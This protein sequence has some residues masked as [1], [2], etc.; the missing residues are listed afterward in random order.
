MRAE[1]FSSSVCFVGNKE[2]SWLEYGDIPF[3]L[4]SDTGFRNGRKEHARRRGFKKATEAVQV[5]F[6]VVQIRSQWQNFPIPSPTLTSV[7]FAALAISCSFF[8][9]QMEW[10]N[11]QDSVLGWF[12]LK[13]KER[14]Y[15]L[16]YC[17]SRIKNVIFH[18]PSHNLAILT[19]QTI[20]TPGRWKEETSSWLT[21]GRPMTC[22]PLSGVWYNCS[23][24]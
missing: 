3:I 2:S 4:Q 5:F 16:K 7:L 18:N 19:F 13:T 1:R 14:F 24:N 22:V 20:L 9:T 8:A 21:Q 23:V 11:T 15:F 12:V 17:F 10:I 6:T